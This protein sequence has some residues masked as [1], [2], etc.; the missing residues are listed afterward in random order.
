MPGIC[1]RRWR[2]PTDV[3]KTLLAA[4]SLL[5]IVFISASLAAAGKAKTH[6]VMMEANKF[7]PSVLTVR[8]GDTIVWVNKD[9]VAH[10]ATSKVAGFDSGLI[11]VGKSWK[12]K[13]RQKGDVPYVCTFHPMMTGTLRVK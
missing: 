13:V 8:S 9:L 5:V 1:S 2:K 10:T 7:V 11:A 3:R 6:T 4:V 12:Y